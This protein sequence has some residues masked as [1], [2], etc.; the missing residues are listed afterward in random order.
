MNFNKKFNYDDTT[1]FI[2]D[3]NTIG[4]SDYYKQKF[5]D[6]LPYEL[7]Q[8]LEIKSRIEYDDDD[9]KEFYIRVQQYKQ[10]QHHKIMKEFLD[11]ENEGLEI[12]KISDNDNNDEEK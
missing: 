12:N 3:N 2:M 10:E 9:L 1:N 5:Y 11:R 7:C 8:E 6:K 4:T